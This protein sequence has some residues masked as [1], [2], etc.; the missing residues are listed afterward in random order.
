MVLAG[1]LLAAAGLAAA[2]V[3]GRW[4]LFVPVELAL[5]LGFFMLHSVLQARA[6]EMLPQARATAVATFACLLFLGQSAGALLVGAAIARYGYSAAFL[7]DAGGI[8]LLT[9]WLARMVRRGLA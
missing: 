1:G 5:G 7:L 9:L 3:S 2:V 6:T 4:W 8:V